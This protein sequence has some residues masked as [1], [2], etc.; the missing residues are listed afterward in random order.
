MQCDHMALHDTHVND[1]VRSWSM[2][3][4]HTYIKDMPCCKFDKTGLWVK[5]MKKV[6]TGLLSHLMD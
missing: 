4:D 5:E 2:Y 3:E 1:A 6:L